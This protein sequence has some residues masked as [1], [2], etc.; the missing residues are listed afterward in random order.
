MF[1]FLKE[2]LKSWVKKSKEKVEEKVE[3]TTEQEIEGKLE[4][5]KEKKEKAKKKEKKLEKKE[6]KIEKK[7]KKEERRIQEIEKE[8]QEKQER[9]KEKAEEK[10]EKVQ[11]EIQDLEQEKQEIEEKIEEKQEEIEQEIQEEKKPSFFQKIKKAI[12]YQITKEDFNEIFED[13][14]LLLLENN[15]ALEVVEAIKD[16]LE[17][18]LIGKQIK[19]QDIEKEIKLSL[20]KSLE[21]IIIEPDDIIETIKA[22]KKENKTPFKVLF[23]GINGAGKTTAIAKFTNLCQKNNLS[24]VLAAGDT[25]RAA[26]MEQLQ[27]HADKLKVKM[28]KHDYGSDPSAVAFDA[29]KHAKTHNIDVVLVDTAGRMHTKDDLLREMEKIARVSDA[30][31]KIFVAEAIAG[32]DA[33]EQ[34]K[35]FNQAVEIDGSILTKTDIDEK[36]GTIISISHVTSKPI[37]YLGTGQN[38]EDLELFDK[39]KFIDQLGLED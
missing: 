9:I 11:E 39:K 32:N 2:K 30:D 3:E 25:F 1:K 17:K 20:K 36:G 13:L 15:V 34:A 16:S 26:S 19:K 27:I 14:E 38:Y 22:L 31:L 28:I 4:E 21:E 33:T 29:I 18:D 8:K 24:C 7:E 23:F 6:K 37:L 10:K 5:S 35:A 12:S